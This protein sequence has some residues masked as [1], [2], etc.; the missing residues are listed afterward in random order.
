MVGHVELE[1]IGL[2]CS[3]SG[4][5]DGLGKKEGEQISERVR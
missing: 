5:D 2:Q 1:Y 4:P 3:C